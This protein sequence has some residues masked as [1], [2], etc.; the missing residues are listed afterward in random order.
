M[1]AVQPTRLALLLLAVRL[2]NELGGIIFC[3]VCG[4]YLRDSLTAVKELLVPSGK[5]T[6]TSFTNE[7]SG[8]EALG[9]R[10]GTSVWFD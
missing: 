3:D 7:S 6:A 5:M 1:R 2:L 10:Q 4:F 9:E 8:G